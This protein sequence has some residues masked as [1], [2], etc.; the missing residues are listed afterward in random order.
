MVKGCGGRERGG[1]R[2]MTQQGG[3]GNYEAFFS[4]HC[5]LRDPAGER[6][7]PADSTGAAVA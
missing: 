7:R 4:F 2:D 1:N 6:R 5:L 3:S